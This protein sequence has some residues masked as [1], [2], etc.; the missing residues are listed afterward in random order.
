[1]SAFGAVPGL[2][3]FTL[4]SVML[5]GAA[6]LGCAAFIS[7]SGEA[8]RSWPKVVIPVMLIFTLTTCLA[9]ISTIAENQFVNRVTGG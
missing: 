4:A 7:F 8:Q 5:L 6:Y 9:L 3:I 2:T 1:M